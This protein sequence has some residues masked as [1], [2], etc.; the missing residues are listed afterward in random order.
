MQYSVRIV[1][2]VMSNTNFANRFSCSPTLAV[3]NSIS[4]ETVCCL[5]S[6]TWVPQQQEKRVGLRK[7]PAHCEMYTTQLARMLR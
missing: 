6:C 2:C 1:F 7:A 5:V 4:A 3:E